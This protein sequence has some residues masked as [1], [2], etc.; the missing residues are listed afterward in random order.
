[1]RKRS[2]ILIGFLVVAV[3]ALLIVRA[4][5]TPP[6]EAVRSE[7]DLRDGVLYL[8]GETRPFS[9]LLVEDF[10][11][12]QRKLAIDVRYGKVNGISRG[13]YDNGQREVEETF[14]AGVSDGLRTRWHRNGQ[15]KSEEHIEH[16]HVNGPYVEWYDNGRKAVTMTVRD[17]QP[18]GE[19]MAWYP[20]GA[21]KSRSH[22]AGGKMVDREFFPSP[23]PATEV[24]RQ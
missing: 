13:W 21:P 17:G 6:R 1:M 3:A 15:K 23:T 22:F 4:L 7:L 24:A 2:Q 5:H 20:D 18:E 10:T 14:V 9:G 12:G 11:K 16:G 8:H 19:V